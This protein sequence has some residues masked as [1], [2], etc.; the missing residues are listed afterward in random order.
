M[1]GTQRSFTRTHLLASIAGFI[2]G[3]NEA[4]VQPVLVGLL[5]DERHLTQRLAGLVSTIEMSGFAVGALACAALARRIPWYR[6]L[7]TALLAGSLANVLC[8]LTTSTA[9]LMYL[10]FIP[11]FAVRTCQARH[12]CCNGFS[13]RRAH[14]DLDLRR[15]DG[16]GIRG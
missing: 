15:T 6:L 13:L 3:H 11:G 10:R 4:I 14:C 16:S 7:A 12:P 8:G 9:V 2:C 5:V 1:I